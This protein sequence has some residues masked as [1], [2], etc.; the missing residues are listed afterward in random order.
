M[1]AT[2]AIDDLRAE[3]LVLTVEEVAAVLRISVRSAYE[4][5]RRRDIPSIRVGNRILIPRQALER[6]LNDACA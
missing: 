3:D 5:V 1:G 4:G 2:A 6:K